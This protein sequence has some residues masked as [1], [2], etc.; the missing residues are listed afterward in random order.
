VLKDAGLVP[1]E[2]VFIDDLLENITTARQA[3][4]LAYHLESEGIEELF[5]KC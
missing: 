5:V 1:H 2:T 4:I 3:G